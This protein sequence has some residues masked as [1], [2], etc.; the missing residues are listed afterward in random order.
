MTA[1]D[2]GWVVRYVA[3]VRP[4]LKATARLVFAAMTTPV[5]TGDDPTCFLS[6]DTIAARVGCSPRAVRDAL[7]QLE[8]S[9]AIVRDGWSGPRLH[10]VVRWRLPLLVPIRDLGRRHGDAL[11]AKS[12]DKGLPADSADKHPAD[13]ADKHPADSAENPLDS[14]RPL[15][16]GRGERSDAATAAASAGA[17]ATAAAPS[18]GDALV[19]E[20][21]ERLGKSPAA[22]EQWIAR[23]LAGGGVKNEP[24]WIRKCIANELEQQAAPAKASTARP[25]AKNR[26]APAKS[27][28]GAAPAKKRLKG[29]VPSAADR[30]AIVAASRAGESSTQIGA[31]FNRS[32]R[33]VETVRGEVDRQEAVAALGRGEAHDEIASALAMDIAQVTKIAD[34]LNLRAV[35]GAAVTRLTRGDAWADVIAEASERLGDSVSDAMQTRW[36]GWADRERRR[37]GLGPVLVPAPTVPEPPAAPTGPATTPEPGSTAHEAVRV[38]KQPLSPESRR[39]WGLDPEPPAETRPAPARFRWEDIPPSRAAS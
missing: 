13:S 4:D 19:T 3:E 5:G 1:L 6:Q 10:R 14:S 37:K 2:A 15:G 32:A 25:A 29:G 28:T 11:S 20:V 39:L 12:A 34:D 31:R 23:K 16:R 8:R 35:Q 33:Q 24:A 26:T 36:R 27:S 22:A 21:V 38:R 17:T 9:G 7:A 30:A 18:T